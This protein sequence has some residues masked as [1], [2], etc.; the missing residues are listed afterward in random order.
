MRLA[1]RGPPGTGA[2]TA[3]QTAVAPSGTTLP[4]PFVEASGWPG[5]GRVDAVL[6]S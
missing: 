5:A 1:A 4:T 3:W 2:F 6:V